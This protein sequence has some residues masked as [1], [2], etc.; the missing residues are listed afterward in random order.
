VVPQ[1]ATGGTLTASS[2]Q[3]TGLVYDGVTTVTTAAGD[4]QV[5]RLTS[6]AATLT[7]L[8]LHVPC[9]V[10]PDLGSGLAMDAAAA[11]GSTA[12]A[13]QGITV[14]AT[15]LA[16]TSAA[17]P[18]AWTPAAPPPAAQLGDVSLTGLTIDFAGIEAPALSVPGLREATSFCTP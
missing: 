7:D 16:A 9:T 11:P 12:A 17:G 6:T 5:L 14:Y 13:P 18:V 4:T 1:L 15:S 2:A 3:L 10:V 8:Q